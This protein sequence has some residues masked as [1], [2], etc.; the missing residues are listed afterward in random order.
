MRRKHISVCTPWVNSESERQTIFF[1]FF[2]LKT[3][4]NQ[5]N[6]MKPQYTFCCYVTILLHTHSFTEKR[7]WSMWWGAKMQVWVGLC[8]IDCTLAYY[9]KHIGWLK[10]LWMA[11]GSPFE[12]NFVFLFGKSVFV[13]IA[14]KYRLY[15]FLL[16]LFPFKQRWMMVVSDSESSSLVFYWWKLWDGKMDPMIR[17][18]TV[19]QLLKWIWHFMINVWW[20]RKWEPCLL[21]KTFWEFLF[22][23]FVLFC[24]FVSLLFK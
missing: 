14:F 21:H 8:P 19:R 3:L 18:N 22:R 6:I 7:K 11:Y 24:M 2:L 5:K 1:F 23:L 9:Y 17:H 16:L 10:H 13:Y 12:C 20:T 15:F 4:H